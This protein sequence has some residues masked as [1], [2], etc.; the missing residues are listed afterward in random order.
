MK[1]TPPPSAAAE[2]MGCRFTWAPDWNESLPLAG[3]T[4]PPKWI[5]S[6]VHTCNQNARDLSEVSR[7]TELAMRSDLF[8]GWKSCCYGNVLRVTSIHGG[9]LSSSLFRAEQPGGLPGKTGRHA[10]C[11]V[12]KLTCSHLAYSFPPCRF[13]GRPSAV[14]QCG[15]VRAVV[16]V[17]RT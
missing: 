12:E 17:E 14:V 10:G 3:G 11:R 6:I 5:S 16:V 9:W 13:A 2:F 8:A 15:V 4:N 1:S 7:R